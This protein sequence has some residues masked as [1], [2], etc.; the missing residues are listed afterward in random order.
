MPKPKIRGVMPAFVHPPQGVPQ[1]FMQ[2]MHNSYKAGVF[3]HDWA[4]G[5]S[6]RTNAVR[7]ENG[8]KFLESDA[9]YIFLVDTDMV[10]EPDAI[11]TL[12]Q[13]A[14]RTGAKA[15]SGWALVPKNG[16]WPHAY[17]RDHEGYVPMGDI[18]PDSA[19]L[20]VDAVGGA[21]FLVHR[22]VYEDVRKATART[23]GYP[24]QEETYNA[25]YDIQSGE[26]ITFCDR[27]N[28]YTNHDIWYHPGAIFF[29]MKPQ[30]LGPSEYSTFQG[31]LR[32]TIDAKLHAAD[33][34]STSQQPPG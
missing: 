33:L 4:S 18:P 9:E 12:V 29:H 11:I 19:P 27:I 8:E 21:C 6:S 15:V 1:L 30:L 25:F 24:W 3:Q 31:R 22:Q 23:T 14:K 13:F 7:T 26:D 16:L 32:Q 5:S 34:Q 17:R 28:K 10:W 20:T 2:A